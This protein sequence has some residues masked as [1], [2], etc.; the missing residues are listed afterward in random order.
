[1]KNKIFTT[2]VVVSWLAACAM[3]WG[4]LSSEGKLDSPNFTDE[5]WP[6]VWVF[7]VVGV[8]VGTFAV[9]AY[10]VAKAPRQSVGDRIQI[11]IA[12]LKSFGIMGVTS[13]LTIA[14]G[15][16][17][18]I[19]DKTNFGLPI[20]LLNLVLGWAIVAADTSFDDTTPTSVETEDDDRETMEREML[21]RMAGYED[22]SEEDLAS[23]KKALSKSKADRG[24]P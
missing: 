9:K 7:A 12:F 5:F 13:A 17:L 1:M 11:F 22:V 16:S 19:L 14:F 15:S 2:A 20:W 23:L 3:M 6:A 24:A 4:L 8:M 18:G 10:P 21:E